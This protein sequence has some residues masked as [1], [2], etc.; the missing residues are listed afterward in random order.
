MGPAGSGPGE[1]RSLTWRRRRLRRWL[2][3][4]L[5]PGSSPVPAQSP[6]TRAGPSACPV[7]PPRA[8]RPEQPA[9][10]APGLAGRPKD[11]RPERGLPGSSSRAV[12]P[13]PAGP[14][15]TP[16]QGCRHQE[17]TGLLR[18]KTRLYVYLPSRKQ[19][20]T[21]ARRGL[22][23]LRLPRKCSRGVRARD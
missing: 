4:L 1:T 12:C 21:G 14:A 7:L 13:Y 22:C 20:H 15:A 23:K 17:V 3:R 5:L 10:S 16:P 9:P 2:L 11:V 18:R 19:R 6:R 8:A